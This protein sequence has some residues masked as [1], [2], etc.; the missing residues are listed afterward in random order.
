[1]SKKKY[2]L[3]ILP[4]KPAKTA[5]MID[6]D[7]RFF[8]IN[9][10]ACVLHIAPPRSGKTVLITNMI[11]N[12]NFNLIEK[13]DAIHIYSSTMDSGDASARHLVE[14]I[15]QTIYNEYSDNHLKKIL[16]FQMSF[17]KSERPNIA[18]F[19][20]D[21]IT[22]PNLTRNSL[23]YK[24]AS[25]YRHYNIKLLYFSS[26]FY[27]AVPVSLRSCIN[28]A[29]LSANSNQRE[30]I[31]MEEELGSRYDGK[32]LKLHREATSVPYA[33]LYLRLY[34]QPA[35]AFRNFTEKIYEAKLNGTTSFDVKSI[36]SK[37]GEVFEDEEEYQ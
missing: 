1:M 13:L 11:L 6:H 37:K 29:L 23:I 31:K 4:I 33:F 22:F 24:L 19:F 8:D 7:E 36:P 12:P 18:I 14:A 15:P 21:F 35:T 10:G 25:A 32:F 26:Q 27:R 3:S 30:L 16:N 5:N 20:D 9:G 28:Y 17:P 2:D 34:D